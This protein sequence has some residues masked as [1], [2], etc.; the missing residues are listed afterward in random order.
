M[1]FRATAA[2]QSGDVQAA[3]RDYEAAVD[4]LPGTQAPMLALGRIADEHNRPSDTRKW[5][6]RA[7]S[8]ETRAVDP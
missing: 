6:E 7:L 3:T 4:S 1:L 2:E 8:P 5:V